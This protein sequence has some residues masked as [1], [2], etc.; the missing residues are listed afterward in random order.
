MTRRIKRS[1]LLILRNLDQ[2][3]SQL[4]HSLFFKNNTILLVPRT[5]EDLGIEEEDRQLILSEKF[6]DGR[7]GSFRIRSHFVVAYQKQA[8]NILY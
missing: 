8:Q 6:Q 7:I 1:H 5:T 4:G 3:Y 2:L